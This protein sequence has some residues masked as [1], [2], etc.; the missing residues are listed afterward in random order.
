MAFNFKWKSFL[1]FCSKINLL[2]TECL[3]PP[4]PRHP[5]IFICW[6]PKPHCD[7][8]RCDVF[9]HSL[10]GKDSAY[11]AGDPS[12]IPGLRRSPEEGI[13]YP[14]TYSQPFLVA[15]MIKKLTYNVGDPGSTP[16]LGRSP[17]GG[18]GNPL[19]Y[20]CLENPHGQRSLEGYSP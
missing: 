1:D 12:S 9:P 19:Q 10:A 11:N 20:S 7:G 15:Q 3:C 6:I 4:T 8:I 5:C 13:G 18:H 14:L 17:V 16:G 2:R